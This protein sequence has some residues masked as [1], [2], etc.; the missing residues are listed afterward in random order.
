MKTLRIKETQEEKIR[1][2]AISINKK[3]V[4]MGKEPLRDSE[5]THEL[6]NLALE[7]ATLDEYGKL[8]I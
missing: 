2:L 5:L 3:L 8:K 4:Q 7:K 1:Q 6:L